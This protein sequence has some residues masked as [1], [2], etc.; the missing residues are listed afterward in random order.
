MSCHSDFYLEITIQSKK[1]GNDPV[2]PGIHFQV[3]L[4]TDEIHLKRN[5]DVL[6]AYNWSEKSRKCLLHSWNGQVS[7][8]LLQKFRN[9]EP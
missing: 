7:F 3:C 1:F 5:F 6:D 9:G 4:L 2:I 8:S